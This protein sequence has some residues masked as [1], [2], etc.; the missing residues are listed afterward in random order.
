MKLMFILHVYKRKVFKKLLLYF[1]DLNYPDSSSTVFFTD[2][3]SSVTEPLLYI[4]IL[5]HIIVSSNFSVFLPALIK[6]TSYEHTEIGVGYVKGISYKAH[7]GQHKLEVFLIYLNLV[8]CSIYSP[9]FKCIHTHC[10]QLM[11]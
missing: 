9:C 1:F 10:T 3:R 8:L 2:L 11:L 5:F 6:E 4:L 7:S